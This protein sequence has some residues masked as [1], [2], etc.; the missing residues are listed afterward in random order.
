MQKGGAVKRTHVGLLTMLFLGNALSAASAS[1]IWWGD[2]MMKL[3]QAN[4]GA[5]GD[6][7]P[8]AADLCNEAGCGKG[9]VLLSAAR[10]EFEPFQI[11]IAAPPTVGLAG[12]DVAVSDLQDGRGNRILSQEGGKPKNIVIYREHY[13]SIDPAKLSSDEAKGGLWPDGLVPKVDEYFGEV[14]RMP[15]ETAPAF[16]FNVAADKKQ[17]IWIDVYVPPATPAGLYTGTAQVTLAGVVAAR[18]PIRLTVYDFDLPSTP[19]LKSAYSFGLGEAAIGHYGTKSIS[20]PQFWELT[21]LYTKEM[22]LH[23]ISNSDVIWPRPRWSASLGT[24]NWALPPLSTTCN[25]RYP[26]FLTGD[27]N[28]LPNGKLPGAKVTWAR[29]RDGGLNETTVETAAFYRDFVQHFT[30]MNWKSQLFYHLWEEPAWSL[31]GGVR[32]CDLAWNGAPSTAWRDLY[33]KAKF[34]R[35]NGID[36]P[37]MVTT[38]RQPAEDCFINY[39]KVPDYTRYIDIWAVPNKYIHG[40]SAAPPPF[41]TNLRGTYDPILTAGK[42]LWWYH[43]C[44]NHGCTGS[45]TGYASPM[46]DLPS[47]YSRIYQWLTYR[48]KV[49]YQAPGPGT[50][51]YYEVVFAYQFSTNDP[52]KNLYYFTGNGD[53]TYFYPGRPDKIGGTTHIPVASI[54]LK[55]LREGME[56]Y[57]YLMLAEEKKNREGIDGALWIKLN[58]IDPYL[59]EKDPVDGVSRFI[60]YAWNREAGSPTSPTGLLRARQEIAQLLSA[61][62]DFNVSVSPATS[63]VALGGSVAA[64]VTATSL[65]GFQSAVGFTCSTSHPAITCQIAPST[66]TPPPNGS[67][68][69]TLSISMTA[70]ADP[71]SYSVQVIGKSGTLQRQTGLALAVQAGR[72][73]DSFDRAAS[74]SLGTAWNEYLPDLEIN[75]NQLRNK[76]SGNKEAQ[77]TNVIG[78]DQSVSVACKVTAAGNACGVTARWSN[79]NN[80]YF[81]RIDPGLGNIALF[82]KVNGIFTRLAVANRTMSFNTYYPIRLRVQGKSIQVF[83]NGESAAAITATDTSLTGRYAGIR[84][85]AAAA[86]STYFDDFSVG[87]P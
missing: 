67:S 15:D 25:Q 47:V 29:L 26:E 36:V 28:L 27:P 32:R 63:V 54:R 76:N 14:R 49:G 58:V 56:D 5:L 31:I 51:L 41:N 7:V 22:L 21:C 42:E 1:T 53:G 12:V 45:E 4:S 3:R 59:T 82:K 64:T 19:R 11:F 48:Y 8:P 50:I 44:G 80:F 57:D 38:G 86:N 70:A 69:V 33:Q 24:I 73:S 35:D 61:V 40:K 16:P 6:P 81:A 17:G 55:M 87:P 60:T 84:S 43:G 62:P 79:A 2:G 85:Y 46:V 75:G 13:L 65:G 78:P 77:F 74:S 34:F 72:F 30:E 9:G 71:G 39:L 20:D 52:W 37:L 18:I 68:T 66:V 23:R 83:F 10:N